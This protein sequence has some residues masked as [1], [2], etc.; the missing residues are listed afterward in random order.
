L[1]LRWPSR[2]GVTPRRSAGP[3]I[4]AGPALPGQG[5][6]TPGREGV[7]PYPQ[8][9]STQRPEPFHLPVVLLATGMV[10]GYE[11]LIRGPGDTYARRILA[12]MSP[13]GVDRVVLSTL[14]DL[15]PHVEPPVW[16]SVNLCRVRTAVG[17]FPPDGRAV[18]E[19]SERVPLGRRAIESL[20]ALRRAGWRVALDDVGAGRNGFGVVQVLRPDIVKV[21]RRLIRRLTHDAAA[22]HFVRALVLVARRIGAT[23]VAEGVETEATAEAAARLG[24][25]AG[26]GRLFG[27]EAARYDPTRRTLFRYWPDG[28]EV[29]NT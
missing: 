13:E 3:Q 26:Q 15:L 25:V 23:V 10:V 5:L 12:T 20:G 8:D 11:L 18:L 19:V 4:P 22:R 16:L 28:M 6:E 9:A 7:G 2:P 24:V 27:L 21:D 14:R 17:L 1:L 29:T